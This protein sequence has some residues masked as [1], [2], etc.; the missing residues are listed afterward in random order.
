MI[1]VTA[2][3][4]ALI[5]SSC[6]TDEQSLR[7]DSDQLILC[8]LMQIPNCLTKDYPD[9]SEV[10]LTEF[11]FLKAKVD[12]IKS[13]E[14]LKSICLETYLP[15]E[16]I[17]RDTFIKIQTKNLFQN[18]DFKT[19]ECTSQNESALGV[20]YTYPFVYINERY[21]FR[22]GLLSKRNNIETIVYTVYSSSLELENLYVENSIRYN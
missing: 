20:I 11:S 6:Q 14:I 18:C 2:I 8:N 17:F 12:S 22:Y 5:T 4:L 3:I 9:D 16:L 1:K 19:D 10:D 15:S 7:R 13:R 21:Y